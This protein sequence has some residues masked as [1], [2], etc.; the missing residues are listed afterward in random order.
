MRR[1]SLLQATPSQCV[2]P[3]PMTCEIPMSDR[4][5]LCCRLALGRQGLAAQGAASTVWA[6]RAH[7]LQLETARERGI[8]PESSLLMAA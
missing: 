5:P 3:V 1:M 2:C 4:V 8:G 6:A 7:P